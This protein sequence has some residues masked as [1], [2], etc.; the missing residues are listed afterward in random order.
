MH[1]TISD[2]RI[3]STD[4]VTVDKIENFTMQTLSR[5]EAFKQL[6]PAYG[7]ETPVMFTANIHSYR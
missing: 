2:D 7:D 6:S 3:L 4:C 1:E 5:Q